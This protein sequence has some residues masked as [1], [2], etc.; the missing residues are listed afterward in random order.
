V[1]ID[2]ERLVPHRTTSYPLVTQD[3]FPAAESRS[4]STGVKG[5]VMI[6]RCQ[7]TFIDSI[8]SITKKTSMKS[9]H[10]TICWEN[11][12]SHSNIHISEQLTTQFWLLHFFGAAYLQTAVPE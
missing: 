6:K 2:P 9:K 5:T 1:T 3:S 4:S 7:R 8:L 12:L 11:P 10:T